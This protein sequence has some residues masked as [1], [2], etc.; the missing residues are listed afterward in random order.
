MTQNQILAALEKATGEQWKTT[1]AS[2]EA[3]RK[4]GHERLSKG[5]SG[6]IF[7][8]IIG[9]IYSGDDILDYAKRR[10]LDN[11][12]LG[13]PQEEPFEVFIEKV[14]KGEEV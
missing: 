5:D 4:E 3:V 7:A 12:A 8:L 11:E 6:G 10:G 2:A 9:T 14:V 1:P 13:L